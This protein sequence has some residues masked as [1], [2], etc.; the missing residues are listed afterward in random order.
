[1]MEHF[2]SKYLWFL[3]GF[4]TI[5]SALNEFVGQKQVVPL[6]PILNDFATAQPLGL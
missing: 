2:E 3:D 1:M 4:P 6:K 5:H